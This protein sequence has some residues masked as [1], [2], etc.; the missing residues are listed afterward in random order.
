MNR[1][2]LILRDQETLE[3]RKVCSFQWK[4]FY[5]TSVFLVIIIMCLSFWLFNTIFSKWVNPLHYYNI[6]S[7]KFIKMSS[8]IQ[9]LETHAK[10][11]E[12]YILMLQSI[13][14]G[15]EL[16]KNV[17]NNINNNESST[18]NKKAASH[19]DA[20]D[21]HNHENENE[22]H[23]T[24]HECNHQ[25]YASKAEKLPTKQKTSSLSITRETKNKIFFPPTN[26]NI[27]SHY[28]EKSNPYKNGITMHAVKHS[29]VCCVN[30]G[31]VVF[32]EF[33]E[34]QNNYVTIIQHKDSILSIY[35]YKAKPLR[36]AGAIMHAGDIIAILDSS[37]NDNE[38][39]FAFELWMDC[40]HVNPED[41]M[42][43]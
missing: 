28:K 14:N 40:H 30:D 1:Y 43:F 24:E 21:D 4:W 37:T 38:H 9:E 33:V 27:I 17:I 39:N 8:T 15:E 29:P 31:I 13:I 12:Q 5:T 42:V 20:I 23:N 11:H 32:S 6:S 35:R 25:V 19:T 10:Q 3:D 7:E 22:S 18:L 26:G 36:T 2:Q 41:Y 16:P 34:S